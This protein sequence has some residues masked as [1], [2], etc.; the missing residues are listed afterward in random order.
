MAMACDNSRRNHRRQ[1][2]YNIVG[3]T[4]MASPEIPKSEAQSD[5]TSRVLGEGM[6][7]SPHR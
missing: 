3:S 5:E 6:F 1:F 2:V 4:K 7:P